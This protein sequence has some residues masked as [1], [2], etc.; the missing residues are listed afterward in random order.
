MVSAG[1]QQCRL[2][3]GWGPEG[4]SAASG[5]AAAHLGRGE[6]V[7]RAKAQAATCLIL[8]VPPRQGVDQA[9]WA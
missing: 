4:V 1:A 2:S 8:G 7:S 6:E 5:Q 9:F 3:A